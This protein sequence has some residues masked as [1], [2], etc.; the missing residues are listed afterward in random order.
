MD[1]KQKECVNRHT[2]TTKEITKNNKTIISQLGV[3]GNKSIE[4]DMIDNEIDLFNKNRILICDT[5]VLQDYFSFQ[6]KRLDIDTKEL[7]HPNIK[8]V[9]NVYIFE[10]FNDN[11]CISFKDFYNKNILKSNTYL[12]FYNKSYDI[13]VLNTLLNLADKKATDI[14]TKVRNVSDYIILHNL[15][16][17][18]V[19]GAYW[20]IYLNKNIKQCDK[21]NLFK[22]AI[23]NFEP[24]IKFISEYKDYISYKYKNKKLQG[25][26]KSTQIISVLDIPSCNSDLCSENLPIGLKTLQQLLFNHKIQFD[27]NTYKS[28]HSIKENN[29]YDTFLTYSANDVVSTEK[30]FNKFVKADIVSRFYAIKIVNDCVSLSDTDCIFAEN[31]TPIINKLFKIDNKQLVNFKYSDYITCQN[32]DFNNFVN[33][34]DTFENV[35]NINPKT[36]KGN[37]TINLNGCECLI[38]VGGIHGAIKKYINKKNNMVDID[39]ASLY[40]NIICNHADLFLHII[41][42]EKYEK[43]KNLRLKYKALSKSDNLTPELKE[44]YEKI[45]TGLK[46][47]LNSTYGLINQDSNKN[48]KNHVAYKKLGLFIC[49][50][51]QATT[52][53]ML[54]NNQDLRPINV[55]TD[56]VFFE[57][58]EATNVDK[59]V[60][61][62]GL[63]AHIDADYKRFKFMLQQDVN[64]YIGIESNNEM[65]LKGIYKVRLK[66]MINQGT[67]QISVNM[68][69]AIKLMKNETIEIEPI[70]FKNLK[71]LK[72]VAYYFTTKQHG[73]S[74]VKNLKI[75]LEILIDNE[76]VY[77]TDNIDYADIELYKKYAQITL[78]NIYNFDISV[79]DKNRVHYAYDLI[80]DSESNNKLKSDNKNRLKKLL[81]IPM[82]QLGYSGF[83]GNIKSNTYVNNSPIKIL[84]GYNKTRILNS[85]DT[86][87][88]NVSALDKLIIIDVDIFNKATKKVKS[89]VDMELIEQ[90]KSIVSFRC[91]NS[92]TEKYNFKV[93][94]K[95]DTN[96]IFS[97]KSEYK[98]YIEILDNAIVW[99]LPNAIRTYYDNNMSVANASCYSDILDK[100]LN[101]KIENAESYIATKEN[102]ANFDSG[103]YNQQINVLVELLKYHGVEVHSVDNKNIGTS[104]PYCTKFSKEHY[105]NNKNKIDAFVNINKFKKGKGYK[106]N[107]H[108]L[109]NSCQNDKNHN[110]FFE[111]LNNEF[112][113]KLPSLKEIEITELISE[114]KE[115]IDITKVVNLNENLL[116]PNIV[117]IIGTGGGKTFGSAL[118]LIE[119]LIINNVF[120]IHSTKENKNLDDF[121]R[122]VKKVL[123]MVLKDNYDSEL[124]NEFIKENSKLGLKDLGVHKLITSNPIQDIGATRAIITNHSYWYKN[125][126]LS[127]NNRNMMSA[128]SYLIANKI[129]NETVIDEYESFTTKG[130]TIMA[131]NAF[132]HFDCDLDTNNKRYT[133]AD[134][135]LYVANKE[136]INANPIYEKPC[137]VEIFTQ[138]LVKHEGIYKYKMDMYGEKNLKEICNKYL[139]PFENDCVD[140]ARRNPKAIV[141]ENYNYCYLVV[142]KV[143]QYK[144]KNISESEKTSMDF[145]RLISESDTITIVKRVLRVGKINKINDEI[146]D[147]TEWGKEIENVEELMQYGDELESVGISF[148]KFKDQLY[149]ECKSELFIEHLMLWNKPTLDL[150]QGTKYYVT[151]NPPK[152]CMLPVNTDFAYKTCKAIEEIDVICIPTQRNA[153]LKIL[154]SLYNLKGKPYKSLIF[155]SMKIDDTKFTKENIDTMHCNIKGTTL[156]GDKATKTISYNTN[157][158]EYIDDSIFKTATLSYLNGTQSQGRNYSQCQLLIQNDKAQIGILGRVQVGCNGKVYVKDIETATIEKLKQS[159]GRL[160]RGDFP[161]KAY[162]VYGDYERRLKIANSYPPNYSIKFNVMKYEKPLQRDSDYEQAFKDILAYVEYK[163]GYGEKVEHF[164]FDKRKIGNNT[165][166]NKY[167]ELEIYNYYVEFVRLN[168]MLKRLEIE[169]EIKNKFNISKATLHRIIKNHK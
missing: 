116:Q 11:D 127:Q 54:I 144:C 80:T 145:I 83:K 32:Q 123:A 28:I 139:V 94:L 152:D 126:H 71:D 27:F 47:L 93:I 110:E 64:N 44:E 72:G 96:K 159:D 35:E 132:I 167:N 36:Y 65:K 7:Q 53:D 8:V 98:N 16:Y 40:P 69:N 131:L 33:W 165:G 66:T 100:L 63:K 76:T 117:M 21:E 148:K 23:D 48:E 108:C 70:F 38:T 142:D 141:K 74:L 111:W 97:I 49:L 26:T 92:T 160:Q 6:F 19:T 146:E 136:V 151:A 86:M 55:N 45:Q 120:H 90:L 57:I 31:N 162:I 138:S 84:T 61:E 51:G 58:G 50:Y 115:N 78:D 166:K 103:D 124:I 56:G 105:L 17:K 134:S 75:P 158:S 85:T 153:D 163:M 133:I 9:D 4:I 22:K 129:E 154:K 25:D 89:N 99:S 46:L 121:E 34:I 135:C 2:L 118:K 73:V 161:Y 88:F 164:N 107:V 29:L 20:H 67:K 79:Q 41:D 157:D 42:V 77:V 143:T 109:S 137:G 114:F 156:D 91:W 60:K 169:Q 62:I 30:I 106:I 68:T 81:K 150:L 130:L 168:P 15:N 95:N 52:I 125:G 3:I 155:T 59:I 128:I 82:D 104:C 147:V 149:A 43:T 113:N 5:E 18:R 12:Y 14:L 1:T 13:G 102:N 101:V 24:G 10:C 140:K 112:T 122:E 37:R 87:S 39:F 119:N